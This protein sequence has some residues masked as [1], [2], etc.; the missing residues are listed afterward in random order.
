MVVPVPRKVEIGSCAATFYSW[1]LIIVG[2]FFTIVSFLTAEGGA[3]LIGICFLGFGLYNLIRIAMKK[4]AAY[5]VSGPPVQVKSSVYLQGVQAFQSQ[6]YD[7]SLENLLL[8]INDDRSLPE[9]RAS[10][11]GLLARI[12]ALQQNWEEAKKV[13]DQFFTLSLSLQQQPEYADFLVRIETH[14]RLEMWKEVYS[15]LQMAKAHFGTK[16]ELIELESRFT[17]LSQD[18]QAE[19]PIVCPSC[20]TPYARDKVPTFCLMCNTVMPLE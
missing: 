15:T 17:S 6:D 5:R 19:L 18:F 16:K 11:L 10:S 7:K 9:I 14:L 13:S 8:V 1:G 2:G 3:F 12:Y 4:D 20:G